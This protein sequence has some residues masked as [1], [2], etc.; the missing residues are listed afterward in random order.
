VKLQAGIV[1]EKI[2]AADEH[3]RKGY[4]FRVLSHTRF[5]F[6]FCL[7]VLLRFEVWL[8]RFRPFFFFF[9]RF[10]GFWREGAFFLFFFFLMGM[11]MMM[12][13]VVVVLMM[14]E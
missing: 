13:V 2:M 4:Q 7:L 10:L 3:N 11:M 12:V 14:N 8:T 6:A 1:S 9:L 5:V